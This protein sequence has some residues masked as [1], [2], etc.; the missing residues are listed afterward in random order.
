VGD[1]AFVK[2]VESQTKWRRR[3]VREE[4][5]PGQWSLREEPAPWLK[6]EKQA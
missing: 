6:G 4:M 5:A 2:Q 1:A 3:F